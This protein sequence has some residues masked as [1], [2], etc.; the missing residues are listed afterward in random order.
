MMKFLRAIP[1]VFVLL[2]LS[3][4][5]HQIRVVWS[6]PEFISRD[7]LRRSIA[8]LPAR[9]VVHPGK[10]IVIGNYLYIN[11][12]YSAFHIFDNYLP[13]VPRNI[14]FLADPG[15]LDGSASQGFLF[16]NNSS[17]LVVLDVSV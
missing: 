5:S 6:A 13:S 1:I 7:S 17:H 10:T 4:C 2:S 12:P 8:L 9:P 14:G 15:G 16:V 3:A 11:E